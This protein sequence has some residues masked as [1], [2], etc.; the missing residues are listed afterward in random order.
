MWGGLAAA[1]SAAAAAER[2]E[3]SLLAEKRAREG[4]KKQRLSTEGGE[5]VSKEETSLKDVD[6]GGIRFF[7]AAA[8]AKDVD[9]GGI[10]F[11]VAAAHAQKG[12]YHRD[13]TDTHISISLIQTADIIGDV[14]PQQNPLCSSTNTYC[15]YRPLYIIYTLYLLIYCTDLSVYSYGYGSRAHPYKP[16]LSLIKDL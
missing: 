16:H 12:L 11:F 8:H 9:R 6:R 1:A 2:K 14:T 10:G 5:E 3:V 7:V 15:V 4:D 13:A